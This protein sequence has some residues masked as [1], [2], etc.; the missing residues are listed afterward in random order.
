MGTGAGETLAIAS[1]L[2]GSLA[3]RV[4]RADFLCWLQGCR[5][6]LEPD[7]AADPG[8]GRGMERWKRLMVGARLLRADSCPISQEWL[9]GGSVSREGLEKPA[10]LQPQGKNI[11][12]V[13]STELSAS[14]DLADSDST[15]ALPPPVH[16]LP[17][18]L[19]FL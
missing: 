7:P 16:L 19:L 10:L 6:D 14:F 11:S 15:G 13:P 5:A 1:A 4:P 3:M 17:L 8:H 9:M 12:V 2:L 18:A